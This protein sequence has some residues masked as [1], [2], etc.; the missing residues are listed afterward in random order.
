MFDRS[1]HLY[2]LIYGFKDYEQ[3][4]RD[5]VTVVRERNNEARR[6]STSLAAPASIFD[7]FDRR[8]RTWKASTWSR[9]CWPS[10]ARSSP[11]SCSPSRHA[12]VRP[13]PHLRRRDVPVLLGRLR[14]RRRRAACCGRRMAAHLAPGGVLVVDG[15]VRPDAWRP[16]GTVIGHAETD[17]EVAV[18]PR[19]RGPA[20]RAIAAV[21]GHAVPGRPP[22]RVRPRSR[23][24]TC[25]PCSATTT[26]DRVRGGRPDPRCCPGRWDPRPVRCDPR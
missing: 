9:T 15:W 8:S 10:R 5:L 12:H 17:E 13:R 20:R 23:R 14:R 19:R 22:R 4:A 21:S 1:A 26:I 7:W 6:C 2:D 16:G 24:P 11:M 18:D 25:S 3:E